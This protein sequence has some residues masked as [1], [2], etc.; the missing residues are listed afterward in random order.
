MLSNNIIQTIAS[1]LQ[2]TELNV[3]REYIQHLFLSY[4]YREGQSDKIFFKGGTALRIIYR[5]PRFSEDLDF[6]SAICSN[7]RIESIVLAVLGE[8]EREGIKTEIKE[9]KEKSGGYLGIVIFHMRSDLLSLQLEIS[10]RKNVGEGEL[11]TVVNDLVPPYTIMRL[12]QRQLI[13]EKI[14]ALR[15]RKKPR[16]YY[17]LYFILRAGL[18]E[19]KDRPV[20]KQIAKTI[21]F[22]GID[23][24]KE[25]QVFLPKSHWPIIK[26]FKQNLIQELQRYI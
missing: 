26:D 2:T 1:K 11:V 18:L 23:F 10:K 3:R 4:F 15:V 21:P 22:V 20:L 5:S 25:L 7:S 16:D 9:S 6:S 13:A 8:M 14:S 17:D 24:K 19:S 12:P